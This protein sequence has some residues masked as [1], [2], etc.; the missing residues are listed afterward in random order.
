MYRPANSRANMSRPAQT[1]ANQIVW[2]S[3]LKARFRLECLRRAYGPF[4]F[5]QQG[6]WTLNEKLW[7]AWLRELPAFESA[8]EWKSLS[9]DSLVKIV[10]C[11]LFMTATFIGRAFPVHD[12]Q[13]YRI[14]R[15]VEL[16]KSMPAPE[17]EP[18][19][20]I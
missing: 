2:P 16:M 10:G 11:A 1:T 14:V 6:R 8:P 18:M 4:Y 12:L 15:I 3:E 13:R 5:W 20:L 7:A 9:L 19:G 17:T